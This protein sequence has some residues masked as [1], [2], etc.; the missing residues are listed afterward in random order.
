MPQ[1]LIEMRKLDALAVGEYRR[2]GCRERPHDPNHESL[3][4][5]VLAQ[6]GVRLR[7]ASRNERPDQAWVQ[8]WKR[9]RG[10]HYAVFF[11]GDGDGDGDGD[12]AGVC[13]AT[14][15]AVM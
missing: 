3:R 15:A 12:V 11:L 9:R 2:D 7:V 5:R 4:G 10:G 8:F 1:A 6:H 14:A 13:A